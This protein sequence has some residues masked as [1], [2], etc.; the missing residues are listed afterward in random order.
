[1]NDTIETRESIVLNGSDTAIWGT[2]HK[3]C[4]DTFG[5]RPYLL[6][7]DRV[8]VVF[9]NLMFPTRA[10]KGDSL[11]YW[12][13]S[14]AKLGY[15]SF[16]FDLP[17]FGDSDGC[18]PSELLNSVDSGEYGDTISAKIT[19]LT[20]RFNLSGVV[21]MGLCAGAVSAL[22]AAASSMECKGLVLMDPYFHLPEAPKSDI[23]IKLVARASQNTLGRLLRG[24]Y[25][26]VMAGALGNEIPS[27]SNFPLLNRWKKLAAAGL[28]MLVLRSRPPKG[29]EFDYIRHHLEQADSN[30]R[31]SVK[32]IEGAYHT[33][34]DRLGREGVR[35]HTQSWLSDY[36]PLIEKA[37]VAAD[38]VCFYPA[39]LRVTANN[40]T[41]CLQR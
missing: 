24:T 9:L 2:Y 31:V 39:R 20:A 36:F 34:S 26:R 32:L 10:G 1:M 30:Y 4:D 3:P 15:P 40:P 38:T 13:D 35:Q 27:N 11:V 14:F 17:G 41:N 18:L 33:F 5:A 22:Y 16:R 6:G 23:R 29:K 25:H 28:P 7:K 12:A 8:G 19:E 21:L 37:E